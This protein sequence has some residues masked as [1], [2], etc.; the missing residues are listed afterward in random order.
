[1]QPSHAIGDLHFAEDRLG[2]E[3]LSN[4]YTWKSFIDD[5]VVVVGGSDAPVEVG[6]PIIEFY[7]AVTRKDLDGYSNEGWNLQQALSREEALQYLPSGQLMQ[8]LKKTSL[9][10]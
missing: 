6:D 1:M 2:F 7:A 4:A 5:G 10:H 3:R 9:E 8:F